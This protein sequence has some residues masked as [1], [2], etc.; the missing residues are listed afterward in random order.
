M[1]DDKYK[2]NE[3]QYLLSVEHFQEYPGDSARRKEVFKGS[4]REDKRRSYDCVNEVFD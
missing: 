2:K 4:Q 1:S 3:R